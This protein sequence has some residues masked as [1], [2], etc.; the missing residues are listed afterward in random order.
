METLKEMQPNENR[1]DSKKSC[2]KQIH[3]SH[4]K[5]ETRKTNMVHHLK[6]AKVYYAYKR[7]KSFP[8]F[9]SLPRRELED[10]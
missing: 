10:T 6:S 4:L 3:A 5:V 8:K 9:L 2:L 1:K 7:W